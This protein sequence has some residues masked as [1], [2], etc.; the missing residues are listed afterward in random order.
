MRNRR[1]NGAYHKWYSGCVGLVSLKYLLRKCVTTNVTQI[2]NIFPESF[3]QTNA[4]EWMNGWVKEQGHL[5]IAMHTVTANRW[6]QKPQNMMLLNRKRL[7][8]NNVT[9]TR[10]HFVVIQTTNILIE[11]KSQ[12]QSLHSMGRFVPMYTVHMAMTVP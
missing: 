12:S 1:K 4:S 7:F 9:V 5:Y 2:E 6:F 11:L 10:K 3:R 8:Y